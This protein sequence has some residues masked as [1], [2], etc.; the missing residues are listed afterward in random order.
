MNLKMPPRKWV[1]RIVILLC[2]LPGWQG[3][4]WAQSPYSQFT[5]YLVRHAE[6]ETGSTNPQLTDC[7]EQRAQSLAASFWNVP[8]EAVYSTDYARTRDTAGPTAQAQRLQVELYNPRQLERVSELLLNRRQNALVVGHSNTTSVLA[9][10]LIGDQME[11]LNES[12]YDRIYEVMVQSSKGGLQIK[13]QGF[14]CA[15]EPVS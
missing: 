5:I 1:V 12:I 10:L 2:L 6:K 11:P 4:G 14:N 8:L 7:G 3:I 15:G 13:L 9:G